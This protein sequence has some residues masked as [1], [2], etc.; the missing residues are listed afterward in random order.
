MGEF[1]SFNIGS[2][3]MIT[4]AVYSKEPPLDLIS[5]RGKI[6]NCVEFLFP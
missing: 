5:V 6:L 3:E 1:N 4:V 2:I